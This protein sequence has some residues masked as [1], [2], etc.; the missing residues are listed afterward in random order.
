[1]MCQYY[2]LI[3][4]QCSNSSCSHWAAI[5][6]GHHSATVTVTLAGIHLRFDQSFVNHSVQ[7]KIWRTFTSLFVSCADPNFH[8]LVFSCDPMLRVCLNTFSCIHAI[9]GSLDNKR[10]DDFFDIK[11]FFFY[12]LNKTNGKKLI[13]G[14]RYRSKCLHFS[15]FRFLTYPLC[16]CRT[17]KLHLLFTDCEHPLVP[18]PRPSDTELEYGFRFLK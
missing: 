7:H 17:P 8:E 15:S 4:S 14:P 2:I 11:F 5:M 10:L 18:S 12:C 3:I 16:V 13:S 9:P 1:M 6:G